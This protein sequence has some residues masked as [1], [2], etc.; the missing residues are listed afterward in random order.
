MRPGI[1]FFAGDNFLVYTVHDKAELVSKLLKR[2]PVLGKDLISAL[3]LFRTGLAQI[4]VV[5]S[6]SPPVM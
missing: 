1:E 4:H 6:G 3:A 5:R 2:G